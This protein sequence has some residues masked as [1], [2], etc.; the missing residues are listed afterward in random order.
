[1]LIPAG[2]NPEKDAG[3]RPPF[4]WHPSYTASDILAIAD[5]NQIFVANITEATASTP[6]IEC[7]T[8]SAEQPNGLVSFSCPGSVTT[9]SF[10]ADGSKLAAV[11]S[12]T[13]VSITAHNLMSL[14]SCQHGAVL[15]G[16]LFGL[17]LGFA[18]GL[19]PADNQS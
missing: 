6:Y 11:A 4:A 15:F 1:M 13:E 8:A 12:Q 16:L 14:L 3:A 9:L 18:F 7:N 17:L 2:S 19:L 10:A 5:D